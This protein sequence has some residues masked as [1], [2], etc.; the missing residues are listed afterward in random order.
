[1]CE[2]EGTNDGRSLNR[3]EMKGTNMENCSYFFF[4]QN[5]ISSS[6]LKCFAGFSFFPPLCSYLPEPVWHAM[7]VTV[8]YKSPFP[9]TVSTCLLWDETRA[10]RSSALQ[11]P[12]LLCSVFLPKPPTTQQSNAA[13]C[14]TIWFVFR[15][16]T[17]KELLMLIKD[18]VSEIYPSNAK[19][20]F[21]VGWITQMSFAKWSQCGH[22]LHHLEVFC[23]TVW[24]SFFKFF[25]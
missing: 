20:W 25:S 19:H 6:V 9:W 5:L 1:M 18:D 21:S 10:I 2:S 24:S 22:F 3:S 8:V 7:T 4:L 15:Q 13:R 12:A 14:W 16:S 17:D 23:F 11:T